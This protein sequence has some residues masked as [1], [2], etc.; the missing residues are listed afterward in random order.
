M[1]AWGAL[2]ARLPDLAAKLRVLQPTK[3]RVV[4]DG[5]VVYAALVVPE[6]GAHPAR[7]GGP[8]HLEEWLLERLALWEEKFRGA[9]EVELLGVWAGIPPRLEF[10]ARVRPRSPSP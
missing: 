8:P 5:Q 6:E 2:R 10:V 3:L 1:T 7:F 4:V 9:R